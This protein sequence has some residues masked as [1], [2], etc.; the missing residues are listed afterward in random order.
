MSCLKRCITTCRN[1]GFCKLYIPSG[2]HDRNMRIQEA[3]AVNL[4]SVH[5]KYSNREWDVNNLM[6]SGSVMKHYSGLSHSQLR[7]RVTRRRGATVIS[8]F[9]TMVR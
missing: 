1:K 5:T 8:N 7:L 9:F 2:G 6:S 4:R 3:A